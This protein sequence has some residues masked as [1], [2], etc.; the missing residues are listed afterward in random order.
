MDLFD[1]ATLTAS[2]SAVDSNELLAELNPQQADA[3][4]HVNGPLLILAGAGS[5][6][7]RVITHRIAWL[8]AEHQVR[9]SSILAITFTNKAADEM[10]QRVEALVGL[11]S[12]SMWI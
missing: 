3:V 4:R 11:R 8:V 10:K 12:Q 9:P 7:T 2:D 5:G 1:Q 6:K